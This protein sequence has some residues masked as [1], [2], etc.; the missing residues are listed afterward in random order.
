MSA[1]VVLL[2]SLLF[3]EVVSSLLRDSNPGY[4]PYT[5]GYN[6]QGLINPITNKIA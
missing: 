2:L 4:Y 6:R 3:Q 1:E 5:N